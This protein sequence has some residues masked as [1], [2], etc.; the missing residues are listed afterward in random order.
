MPSKTKTMIS[1]NLIKP[2]I[3]AS[4]LIISLISCKKF[5]DVDSPITS[6]TGKNVYET[7]ATAIAV[8]SGV[9]TTISQ[10]SIQGGGA[11]LTSLGFIIGLV[12]DELKLYSGNADVTLIGYYK[13]AISS[14]LQTSSYWNSAYSRLYIVNSAIVGLSKPNKITE[15][16]RLQLLGEAKFIRAL[17]Y[18]YLVNMY[19]DLPL[20]T[21]PDYTVNI[22]LHREQ[23]YKIWEQIITDL[24]EAQNLLSSDYLSANLLSSTEERV[25]PTKWAAT[26][27][28]ARTYLYTQN[29]KK[30]EEESSK[31]IDQNSMFTLVPL[32]EKF[33]KNNKEAIWQLQPVL[34]GWNT[35]DAKA[36][37]LTS[38]YGPN[39]ASGV[40]LSTQLLNAFEA[41]DLR[42]KEWVDSIKFEGYS[43]SFAY[44][45]RLNT[46]GESV[47]EYNTVLRLGEQYLIRAEARNNQ[48]NFNGAREDLNKIR[49]E[50][51]LNN[52]NANTEV[53][54]S[55][56]IMSERKVELF[57]E[58]G[59]R[60]FDLKRTNK[61]ND[62]MSLVTPLKGGTWSPNW[63]L[64]P[65]P[66]YDTQANTN[67]GQNT[68]Y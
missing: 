40:Y 4:F 62:V 39:G 56:A 10:N 46:F 57:C 6:I 55:T 31:L 32:S 27:L 18:F 34:R 28:L 47:N 14:R 17:C 26:A 48:G 68:G 7:D 16:V 1:N 45:Y 41:N 20:V 24:T 51:G 23:Q 21:S 3:L 30:A 58:Y 19:G 38:D 54:L 22:S 9:Y 53:E 64:F 60:W 15:K 65:I 29:W 52:T 44:K 35:E 42:K 12:S 33:K 36:Y 43:Y 50:A 67:L 13:N 49:K 11:D 61:I 37:I 66:F 2:I 8:L 25:R 63:Q 59:H 5:V